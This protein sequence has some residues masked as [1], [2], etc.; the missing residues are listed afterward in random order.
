M[1]RTG[2]VLFL[3]AASVA[4]LGTGFAVIDPASS[5]NAVVA[6]HSTNNFQNAVAFQMTATQT[7]YSPDRVGPKWTKIWSTTLNGGLTY[8]LIVDG[9]IYVIAFGSSG[10]LYSLKASTGSVNWSAPVGAVN[11]LQ[12]TPGPAYANNEVFT[13]TAPG[14]GSRPAT[15]TAH[16]A[17]TGATDWSTELPVNQY[18]WY[19][20]TAANGMVY[21]VGG[22]SGSALAAVN[23]K[24]GSLI[25]LTE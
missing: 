14:G 2:S 21:L 1:R 19:P 20:P 17:T 13:D 22:G 24:T 25:G 23:A 16:S 15:L 8:P 5:A 4:T 3:A 9:T 7:G 10:T 12:E 11:N 18:I 6:R